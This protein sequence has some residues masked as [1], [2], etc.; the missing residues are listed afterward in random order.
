MKLRS[1]LIVSGCLLLAAC[2]KNNMSKI[3][4][5]SLV[6]A[7]PDSVKVNLDTAYIVFNYADGDADLG[8]S[9][10]SAVFVKDLRYDTG[11]V[12][13][14]FP[15]IVPSQEDPKKGLTGTGAVL[16]LQPPLTPRSDSMHM[17]H[18]DTTHFEMYITDRAGNAS[19]HITTQDIIIRP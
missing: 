11:Y 2:E 5:I 1:A 18:G 7:G 16:L 12:Q 14:E 9:S 4:Q 17:V 8:N 19:N 10:T 6:E 15:Y 13:Y 3:P